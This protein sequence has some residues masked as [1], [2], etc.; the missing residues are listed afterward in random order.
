MGGRKADASFYRRLLA[1]SP[2]IKA[3]FADTDFAKQHEV[4]DAAIERLLN[5]REGQSEPTTLSAIAKSHQHLGV[6]AEHFE[7]FGEIFLETLEEVAKLDLATRDAWEAVL[8]PGIEYL[9]SR[10][11]PRTS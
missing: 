4:L 7:I 6:K 5:Y 8:W 9:K 10:C 11:A 1:V 3:L 2:E